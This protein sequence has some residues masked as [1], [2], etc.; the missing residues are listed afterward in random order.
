MQTMPES[1][2]SEQVILGS[3]FL[4]RDA[5]LAVAADLKPEHFYRPAHA[6]LYR[7]LC[8][9]HEFGA[10]PELPLVLTALRSMKIADQVGEDERTICE[11]IMQVAECSPTS[12]AQFVE[13]YAN[14]V[15]EKWL[16]RHLLQEFRGMSKAIL[17][18]ADPKEILGKSYSWMHDL[19]KEDTRKLYDHIG[20]A[21]TEAWEFI[22][23]CFRSKKYVTGI[24][25]GIAALDRM[26]MGFQPSDYV[27]VAARPSHG[28]TAFMLQTA[29]EAA[30]EGLPVGIF[31]LEMSATNLAQRLLSHSAAVSGKEIRTGRVDSSQWERLSDWYGKLYKWPI[32]VSDKP[33]LHI[34]EIPVMARRMVAEHG[35]KLL[36]LDYIGLVDTDKQGTREQEVSRVSRTF[37]QIARDL[38]VPFMALSQLNRSLE[39]RQDPE[40]RLSDLRESGSLEQDSDVV[41]LIHNPKSPDDQYNLRPRNA[42][43]LV[44]KQRNLPIGRVDVMWDGNRMRFTD[45]EGGQTERIPSEG[46]DAYEELGYGN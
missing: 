5:W 8:S 23:T 2:E 17:E 6:A 14:L 46:R 27:I 19:V 40:P 22:E 31:S 24:G 39:Y 12:D 28:K 20:P 34:R 21:L 38:K 4:H 45:V 32:Y 35:V 43:L 10:P 42:K 18:G 26:T 7:A 16:A 36:M 30:R 13:H 15:K 9:I 1:L 3:M 41:I 33:G 37:Q 11:Y 29:L 25:T 44:E